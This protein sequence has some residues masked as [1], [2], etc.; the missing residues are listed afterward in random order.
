LDA[1]HAPCRNPKNAFAHTVPAAWTLDALDSPR[2][3]PWFLCALGARRA[4]TFLEQ[5]PEVNPEKLGVYGHSMGGK[6]TVLTAAA[7]DRIKAA[8]PSCGGISNRATDNALYESTIADGVN[9][10]QINC[11]IIFLKPSND[12]HGRLNDLPTAIEE[13]DSQDWRVTCSPHGNHQDTADYQ[14]AG[15]LWFDQHLKKSFTFPKTPKGELT[16]TSEPSFTVQPD[17]SKPILAVDIYYTQH[18]QPEGEK[19]DRENTMNRFSRHATATQSGDLWKG[20]LPLITIDKPLWVYANVVYA[21]DEQQTGAGYYYG[22][23]TAETFN[24]SSMVQMVTS[25]DLKAAGIKATLKPSQM[26]ETFEDGW[27]KE[28]FTYKPEHWARWT[29]K[30]YDEQWAPLEDAKL[31]FDVRAAET[32]TLVVGIDTY[33]AEIQVTGNNEWQTVTLPKA[34]LLDAGNA[35][36][37]QWA[38]IKELRLGDKETLRIRARGER[39]E[40]KRSLGADWK[41]PKPEFR[42]LRWSTSS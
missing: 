20:D 31:S 14:I 42:N 18:G 38:G 33:A 24:L 1:Y 25:K 36:L 16:L 27:V 40:Q 12:F 19:H 11:P 3:N 28:W 17:S 32:N 34:D 35:A 23:Y 41:G 37:S 5:Q 6:L 30:V 22:L 13:I 21:L 9:L 2:N 15:L 29:H 39:K 4:I 26:I 8:A 10:Q 7:D